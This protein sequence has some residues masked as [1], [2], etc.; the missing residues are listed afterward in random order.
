MKR[1]LAV[2][3]ICVLASGCYDAQ[4]RAK[5]RLEAK[6]EAFEAANGRPATIDDVIKLKA[7]AEREER[8]AREAELAKAKTDVISGAG[9]VATGNWIGGGFLLVGAV[10]TFLGLNRGKKLAAPKPPGGDV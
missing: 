10:A 9:G 1:L 3:V 5:E 6:V 8:E 7:D 4:A 2:F